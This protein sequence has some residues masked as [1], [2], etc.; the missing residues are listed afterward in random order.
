MLGRMKVVYG[1]QLR[2]RLFLAG[3]PRKSPAD[4]VPKMEKAEPVK[5]SDILQGGAAPGCAPPRR[6]ADAPCY[7]FVHVFFENCSNG[8]QGFAIT[9]CY[10]KTVPQRK[11]TAQSKPRDAALVPGWYAT[12]VPPVDGCTALPFLLCPVPMRTPGGS[13]C[14]AKRPGPDNQPCRATGFPYI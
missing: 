12:R 8:F 11:S 7:K 5:L 6:R 3:H 1:G 4:A 2:R 13:R 14:R 10:N 9:G